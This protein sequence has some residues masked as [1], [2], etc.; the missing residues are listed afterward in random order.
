MSDVQLPEG[1]LVVCQLLLDH[2]LVLPLHLEAL[3][4]VEIGVRDGRV[5]RLFSLVG[6]VLILVS[7]FEFFKLSQ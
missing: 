3:H 4:R 1:L 2:G 7:L 5:L 6:K